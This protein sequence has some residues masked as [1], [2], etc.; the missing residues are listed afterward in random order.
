MTP[1]IINLY[2]ACIA[3]LTELTVM[4]PPFISIVPLL[5]GS[6]ESGSALIPALLLEIIIDTLFIVILC[7]QA[8]AFFEAVI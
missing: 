2:A 4:I 3:S 6:S 5:F 8:K 1:F 7:S